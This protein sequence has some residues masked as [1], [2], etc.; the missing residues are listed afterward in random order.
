MCVGAGLAQSEIFLFLTT[1][2]RRF[3][4]LPVGSP[5]TINIKLQYTGLDNPPGP[6][7]STWWPTEAHY[8]IP[9]L[10]L[11]QVNKGLTR[12]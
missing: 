2:L 8:P 3:H 4:L 5:A 6:S 10:P 12:G 11:A 9:H 7:G 1:I